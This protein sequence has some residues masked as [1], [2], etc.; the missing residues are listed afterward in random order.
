MTPRAP[1]GVY[2]HFPW[3]LAKCPYCDFYSVPAAR[4]AVPHRSYADAVLAELGRRRDWLGDRELRSVFFGGGTP[5]LWDPRE[6]GRV[7]TGILSAFDGS[8]AEEITVECNPSSLD[9]ACARALLD[10]GVSRLSIGVQSLD[11]RQLQWLGRLH[12]PRGA[13]AALEA[14]AAAG[15]PRVAADLLFGLP[16]A[17]P[18]QAAAEAAALVDHGASHVSTYALTIEAGTRFGTLARAGRLPLA[19]DDAVADAYFAVAGALSARGLVHYETSNHARPGEEA[20]H[21]L[22]YWWGHEYLGLGAGAWGTVCPSVGAPGVRLRY[23]NAPSAGDYLA[24][25][26]DWPALPLERAAPPLVDEVEPIPP[27]TALSERILL[28]LRLATGVDVAREASRLGVDPWPPRRE[29]AVEALVASGRLEREGGVLRVPRQHW[30]VADNVISR[31][32]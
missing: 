17:A 25:A 15:T 5:S 27:E 14:A 12:D 1:L 24:R 32:M 9:P 18:A 28:G 20:R 22:G 2:V 4:D 11:A 29:R 31:V 23:R 16:G 10:V 6:L 8:S 30:F 13:L 26:G 7:L 3:C 21:N 19:P